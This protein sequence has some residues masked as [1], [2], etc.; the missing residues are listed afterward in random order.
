MSRSESDDV[1]E[2]VYAVVVGTPIICM[3][4][5]SVYVVACFIWAVV[6]G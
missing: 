5:Y 1:A 2:C 4:G 6:T 3:I